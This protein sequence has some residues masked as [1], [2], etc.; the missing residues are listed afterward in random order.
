[1]AIPRHVEERRVDH[2]HQRQRLL[3]L[4][5]RCI[6][7]GRPADREQP[8]LRRDRQALVS[9]SIIARLRATLIDLRL[10][11]KNRAPRPTDRS[12]REVS[13][14]RARWQ[15]GPHR[16]PLRTCLP[17][18]R[19]P[20]A[21]TPRSS[22]GG[23]RVSLPAPPASGRPGSPPAPPSPCTPRCSASSS[24]S[25]PRPFLRSGLA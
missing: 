16:L 10:W 4:R 15:P 11:L 12:S 3:T 5:H 19:S 18:F 9:S 23:C 2:P 21:S 22:Y 13:R 25:S 1:A 17:S 8:A 6:V 24:S 20:G 7:V 14:P